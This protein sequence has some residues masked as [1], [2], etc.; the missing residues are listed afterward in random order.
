MKSCIL[1]SYRKVGSPICSEANIEH[2]EQQM[3]KIV[4]DAMNILCGD[5]DDSDKCKKYIDN[6]DTLTN[7]SEKW[8]SPFPPAIAI[9]E[10]I[11]WQNWTC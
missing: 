8:R 10:S 7:S 9:L 4:V 2:M 11:E 6:F 3:D 5:Y 1:G